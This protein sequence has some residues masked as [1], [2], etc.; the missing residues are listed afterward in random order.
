[1]SFANNVSQKHC[2]K[3]YLYSEHYLKMD[4]WQFDQTK[5]SGFRYLANKECYTRAATLIQAYLNKNQNLLIWQKANLNWH[6]GQMLAYAGD[7]KKAISYMRKAHW[8]VS[9]KLSPLHWNAYVNAT[10]AFLEGNKTQLIKYRNI[11]KQKRQNKTDPN[12]KIVNK[13]VGNFGKSY[14]DVY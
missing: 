6:A 12:L 2:Q 1:M 5:D 14:I 7:Y 13:L 8:T 3:L 11:L 4:Y 10:I 9:K